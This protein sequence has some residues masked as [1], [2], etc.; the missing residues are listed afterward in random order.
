MGKDEFDASIKELF[1]EYADTLE[2]L[3]FCWRVFLREFKDN[4]P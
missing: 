3:G 1:D 4:C 2:Q